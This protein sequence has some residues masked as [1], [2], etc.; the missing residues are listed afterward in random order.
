M[1]PYQSAHPY[2]VKRA[3]NL[4]TWSCI[5]RRRD[6]Q[7]NLS[8]ARRSFLP[9]WVL[10]YAL[11]ASLC[12]QAGGALAQSC[13]YTRIP[14]RRRR[15]MSSN[16]SWI[17]EANTSKSHLRAHS[18]LASSLA[19]VPCIAYSSAAAAGDYWIICAW[20]RRI[21]RGKANVKEHWSTVECDSIRL[22][23]VM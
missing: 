19:I 7:M 3:L 21:S 13:S 2:T 11:P 15:S 9:K 5:E 4:A 1:E 8:W 12:C 17:A 14:S 22:Y 20:Y 10:V 23:N 6:S 16:S 18:P